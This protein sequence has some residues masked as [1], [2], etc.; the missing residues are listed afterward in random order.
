MSAPPLILI[1]GMHRSGT[2][3]LGNLLHAAGVA[4]PGPLIAGDKHNPEGYFE[5]ADITDLQEQLLIDLDRWWPSAQGMLPLPEGWL[6]RPET[7][8]AAQLL[9]LCLTNESQRQ[10]GPWAIKDPRSS[11]LLPLWQQ[12]CQELAIPLRLVLAVRNPAEVVISL[13]RRDADAAGM[14]AER[15]EQLWCHH[16]QTVLAQGA[17]LPLQVID[18]GLWFSA[19]PGPADQLKQLL[20]FCGLE[21]A[22]RSPIELERVLAQIKPQHRRSHTAAVNVSLASRTLKLHRAL[23]RGNLRAFRRIRPPWCQ[24]A[25]TPNRESHHTIRQQLRALLW[26]LRAQRVRATSWDPGDWFDPQLYRSQW[27]GLAAA[28]RDALLHH[29]RQAGWRAGTPPHP[30]F[31]PVHYRKACGQ[32]GLQLAGDPLAHWLQTGLEHGLFPSSLWYQGWLQPL[33]DGVQPLPALA[34]ADVHPWGAAAEALSAHQGQPD[35]AC[36]LLRRWLA[37]GQLSSTDLAAIAALPNGPLE[38]ST[39]PDRTPRTGAPPHGQQRPEARWSAAILGG[40]WSSWQNHALLQHLPIALD[41]GGIRWCDGLD[42]STA[43]EPQDNTVLLHLQSLEL[44]RQQGLLLPLVDCLVFDPDPAQVQ[45]LRRLGVKAEVMRLADVHPWGA[46]A[47]ALS[48]HQGQPDQACALLRRWLAD[49]QLSSTDLAAIA[50]LPNGPLERSTWP[51][52]TPRTGAPPHGQQRPEARWSAAIL[53]GSWSSWQNHALLQHLPI[54]LDAGGIRWCDGLDLSTAPEPQDNTV[55]LHLQSL[56]LTR[57]QGLLL[58]LVDC[59]VF[60]PDPAQVQLL[61]R[62]GVKAEEIRTQAPIS[63]PLNPADVADA[64]AAF[65]L[66]P[67]AALAEPGTLSHPAVLCLGTAGQ[68]WERQLDQSCWCLPGFHAITTHSVARARQLAAWLQEC[69]LS[70]VQLVDLMP[71]VNASVF[72]GFEALA[73]PSPAPAGWL[74]VQRFTAEITPF[75]LESELTWLREGCPPP[76]ACITPA[77]S[78]R[79]L[80]QHQSRVPAAAV[81]VSLFNYQHRIERALESVRLQTLVPLELIVVDDASSDGGAAFVQA[82]LER[83]GQRFAR[84]VLLQHTSNGGLAA[85]RNTAFSAAEAPWCFVLDADNQLL[86]EAVAQCLAVAHCAPATASVVHPL[87][88]LHYEQPD[89]YPRALLSQQSWQRESFRRGNY[90]DAMALVRRSAWQQVGGYTH[91]PGG[92]EDFDLWCSLMDAGF[93]GVMCPKRLAVYTVHGSSMAATSTRCLERSISRLLQHRH[94][95]LSLP[96]AAEAPSHTSAPPA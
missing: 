59:L 81:C 1:V 29:Y 53:G 90:V 48:A 96:L 76:Q 30:L 20:H 26:Q 6:H 87:V 47:E 37:D 33:P 57:Q 23:L 52:R 5:R 69:Q 63:F 3:L 12:V 80:W 16:N 55:L 74:P 60:D 42:L 61:R 85:A 62:L 17:A 11:L 66:P 9:N 50:A 77:P 94:P 72:D 14:T 32:A 51:D 10:H 7:Q 73:R 8:A 89:P 79:C 78:H 31:D 15:A 2:S 68:R 64:S 18:Y 35:Q 24:V 34:L 21:A 67:P 91:I 58:P 71:P 40:S 95:W 36:A 88:A 44:T 45:L 27:P 28:S 56:E 39:W 49:G 41:A 46:A 82:W 93:H 70:G 38:R 25:E 84:A 22:A 65:G 86:A 75:E 43:P 54:A 13:C 83:H 4:L 19:G 92:W